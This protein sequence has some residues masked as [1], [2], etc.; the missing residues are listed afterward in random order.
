MTLHTCLTPNS[1]LSIFIIIVIFNSNQTIRKFQLCSLICRE[2]KVI[3]SFTN[4]QNKKVSD[5]VRLT[6]TSYCIQQR[7]QGSNSQIQTIELSQQPKKKKKPTYTCPSC[8]DLK[9][10]HPFSILI[11]RL[12]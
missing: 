10:H 2:R 11:Q 5:I 8:I 1:S 4:I 3:I 6:S 12:L 9:N 7:H